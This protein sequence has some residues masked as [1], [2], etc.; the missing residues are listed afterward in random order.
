MKD[1]LKSWVIKI[2]TKESELVLNKFKPRVIAIT[3]NVGKT[4]TK[5]FVYSVLKVGGAEV[6]AAEKSQNSEFGVC[7]TILGEK[8]AWNNPAAWLKLLTVGFVKE[9]FT[10]K[11]KCALKKYPEKLILE[12]GA[13]HPGDIKHITSFVKPDV[14]VLT[15][16]QKTPTHGEF[17]ATIEQ[18]IREKKYLVDAIKPGGTICYNADDEV[19]SKMARSV[20]GLKDVKLISFGKICHCFITVF[21]PA[22]EKMILTLKETK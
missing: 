7:L 9:Y 20:E 17:F 5:D 4:T 6:R 11:Y 16:F 12:I 15:A 2:L 3:G 13:D 22:E 18:H 21:D 1:K 8:N 10:L 14:V 19:M